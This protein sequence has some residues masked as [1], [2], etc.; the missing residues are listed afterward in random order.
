[1]GGLWGKPPAL[2]FIM[3]MSENSQNDHARKINRARAESAESKVKYLEGEVSRLHGLVTGQLI[4]QVKVLNRQIYD[5]KRQLH[6]AD[7]VVDARALN[8]QFSKHTIFTALCE[9]FSF[10]AFVETGTHLGSTTLFLAGS[11]KPVYTV[12]SNPQFHQKASALLS[13]SPL[14]QVF[15]ED[16]PKFLHHLL[17]EK[18]AREDLVFFYLDAHWYAPLPLGDEIRQIAALHPH[19]VVMIDDMKVEGDD[20]Y[21]YDS[22]GDQEEISL[23][24]LEGALRE[25]NWRVFFPSMLSAFDHNAADILAPRGTAI[26]SCDDGIVSILEAMNDLRGW[27]I[28]NRAEARA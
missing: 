25:S 27:R 28:G 14:V 5:L 7:K 10:D 8:G 26:A 3:G 11:G 23:A 18:I 4:E 16:S 17:N 24:Y 15:L 19:G 12:E 22:N 9:R 1:L 21:G 20:G 13:D 2:S 6:H